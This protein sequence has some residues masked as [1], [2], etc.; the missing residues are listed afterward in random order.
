MP[1]KSI[2]APAVYVRPASGAVI[3]TSGGVFA[4]GRGTTLR[5]A[6]ASLL[7][8]K[9]S[10]TEATTVWSPRTSVALTVA[11]VPRSPWRSDRQASDAE[12]SSPAMSV[13]VPCNV[14]GSPTKNVAPSGGCTICTLGAGPLATVTRRIGF[15]PTTEAADL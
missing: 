15:W 14:T 8:P 13:A 7:C 5:R 2:C 11:P 12:M 9:L 3:A 1:A 10:V 6:R 4:G